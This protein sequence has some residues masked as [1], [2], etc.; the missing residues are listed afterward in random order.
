MHI[1]LHE[2]IYK[3]C[4]CMGLSLSSCPESGFRERRDVC[5]L[6]EMEYVLQVLLCGQP[7][8]FGSVSGLCLSIATSCSSEKFLIYGTPC[9][10]F[11]S[12]FAGSLD[13]LLSGPVDEL[14]FL[15]NVGLSPECTAL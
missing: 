14:A 7:D 2:N 5:P 9:P 11:S 13:S 1:V 12:A 4:K 8:V 6:A 3:G 15:R 10:V